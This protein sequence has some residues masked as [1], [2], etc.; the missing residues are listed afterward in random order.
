M[1]NAEVKDGQVTLNTEGETTSE[2]AALQSSQKWSNITMIAGIVA[3]I[4][5]QIIEIFKPMQTPYATTITSVLGVIIALA[6]VISRTMA[7]SSYNDTRLGTKTVLVSGAVNAAQIQ[8]G[9]APTA[10][11]DPNAT[12]SVT[13]KTTETVTTVNDP[14][15]KEG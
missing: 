13:S 14:E 6:G 10:Q 5:P 15:K 4:G 7:T 8:A 3:T 2:Y 12:T 11:P 1:A 9:V